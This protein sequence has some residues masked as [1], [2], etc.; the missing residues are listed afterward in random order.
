MNCQSWLRPLPFLR[1]ISDSLFPPN[2]TKPG[3]TKITDVSLMDNF[4][5]YY[6]YHWKKDLP[7]KCINVVYARLQSLFCWVKIKMSADCECINDVNQ[8]K[9]DLIC[10]YWVFNAIQICDIFFQW[11]SSACSSPLCQPI[12]TSAKV[13]IFQC[14]I[15]ISSILL[16]LIN[17]L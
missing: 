12:T 13:F 7:E 5:L 16:L 15:T 2:Q 11:Q 1:Y 17:N 8:V 4:T 6:H 9:F 3:S 14:I 10:Y